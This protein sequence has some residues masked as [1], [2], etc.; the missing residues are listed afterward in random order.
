MAFN[1]SGAVM[2]ETFLSRFDSLDVRVR[3]VLQ[4]CAVLGL[5][6]ALSD[7]IQV[8]P[9]LEEM[10]IED[11]LE[12]AVDEMI[13]LEHVSDDDETVSLISLKSGGTNSRAGSSNAS[14]SGTGH[15]TST[16]A[17][18]AERGKNIVDRSFQ[19]SH[20]MWRQNVLT[21][22]LKERKIELH[23]LIAQAMERDQVLIL[24]QSDITR[25]LTL[26]EH[27]KSCGDFCKTAPL[28]LAVGS[29]LEEWDLSA[30]SLELYED[31][32]EMSYDTVQKMEGEGDNAEWV[33]V[34]AKPA[35][36]DYILR[37]H[38]RIGLCHQ[39]LGDDY[40]SICMFEDA[41]NIIKT[42]SKLPAISKAL[43]MPIISSLCVLKLEEIADDERTRLEQAKLAEKFVKEAVENGNPVH[44]GRALAMEA[45]HYARL[46]DFERAF[47]SF[48]RLKEM[49][50]VEVNSFDMLAEYGRDFALECYCESV[51]WY[52]LQEMHEE[53][54]Q[55]ADLV[56]HSFLPLLHQV[57]VDIVM[58]A[59]LPLIQVLKLIG[60]AVDA[61]SLLKNYAIDPY[62]R[63]GSL[64]DFW[65]PLFNPL[66]Y[67]L[68]LIAMEESDEY[69]EQ[70]LE[71]VGAWVID[72]ENHDYGE[73][74]ERE[75]FT[76]LGEICWRLMDF[77]D[78]DDPE[79]ELL[80]EKARDLLEPIA[81]YPHPDTF[82]KHT[83]QALIEAL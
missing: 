38:I 47:E 65:A 2:E 50:D 45:T 72:E 63:D 57:D 3:K 18:S 39:N 31:C 35:V 56:I 8:H 67:L 48:E 16:V 34:A 77:K 17:R 30:Q 20:A 53:A 27:W 51:Q 1:K 46:E 15:T 55:Q 9:E 24:E 44:I 11:A 62:H 66:A 19:F 54:E 32:L 23:R 22:M 5:S 81:S 64:A 76:I 28:A 29:R 42:T 10:D 82:L 21:T 40:E 80:A 25:L 6:F 58:Y 73:E 59:L 13:L 69:D 7:V 52:Y 43:M 70:L 83:A 78:E 79:R 36:L 4:T 26:F 75:A 41:Y 14:G 68:D 74:L 71:E 33:H 37:L 61:E 49:Y 60:R 12:I